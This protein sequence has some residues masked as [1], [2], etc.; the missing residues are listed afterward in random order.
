TLM[1]PPHLLDEAQIETIFP[2]VKTRLYPLNAQQ[3]YDI[4]LRMVT[5]RGWDISMQ[6][7]P[8]TPT[9]SGQINARIVTLAGWREEAVLLVSGTASGASVDMRS[10]SINA[11]HDFGSNGERIEDFLV[12]LDTEVTTLLRDNPNAD[13]PVDADIDADAED[14]TEDG[15][16]ANT[17]PA[18]Q[19]PVPAER[20]PVDDV[21]MEM[22]S[23][24]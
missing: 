23:P 7:A 4:V 10:A 20:P 16:S 24:G 18:I 3:T 12:A 5:D 17:A 15:V 8:T 2:N 9:G 22:V 1:P 21:P 11:L 14:N 19:A 6:R 13:Q